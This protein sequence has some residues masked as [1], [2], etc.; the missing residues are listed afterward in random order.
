MN[1]WNGWR[2]TRLQGEG[3]TTE[4]FTPS[5]EM[6]CLMQHLHRL[7]AYGYSESSFIGFSQ[8]IRVSRY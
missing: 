5:P 7:R 4:V 3:G 1:A 2:G 8:K 6:N